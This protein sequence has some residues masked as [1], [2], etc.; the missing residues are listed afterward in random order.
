MNC[1]EVPLPIDGQGPPRPTVGAIA[2]AHGEDFKRQHALTEAQRKVLRDISA[3]RTSVLGGRVDVCAGCGDKKSVFN[4]CRNRHCPA[5]Q[6]LTQARWIEG[7][8]AR[9]LPTDYFHVVFTVPDDLIAS[10]ALRNRELFFNILFAA[11]SQTLLALGEDEKRLGAQLGL[12]A[13]LHTWTRDLR[14]HPHLHCIVTGGGLTRDGSRWKATKQDYLFPVSVMSKLFCGKVMAALDEAYRAGRL[15]LRGVEGFGG[16]VPDEVAWTRLKRKLYRT[17]WVSYAKPPFAGPEAVYRYLG[18]YTHRVGLSNHR[19][20]ST[21]DDAVTFRT[22]GEQTVSLRPHE[23][24]RRFL[25]HVLPRGFVKL[26]HYG[27]LAPGNVNTKLVAALGL[28]MT[29]VAAITK[30]SPSLEAR[31][32]PLAEKSAGWRELLLRL[33]GVDLT[34]CQKCGG[35]ISSR[36]LER[37][38]PKDT[39]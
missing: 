13:V 31:L 39:S 24:L 21:T 38:P 8:L 30:P 3:C 34:R 10:L 18:R 35:A 4:S 1:H 28:L 19:L 37:G 20:V 22:R 23:F 12:T 16:E 5:C 9:L 32:N 11:G 36:A 27:L 15:E 26:R 29:A 14:F 33:T 2:R 6:S 17:K 7:R 25:L